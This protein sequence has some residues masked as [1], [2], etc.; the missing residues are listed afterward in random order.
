MNALDFIENIINNNNLYNANLKYCLINKDKI[1][2]KYNNELAKPNHKEDF[3]DIDTL[4]S[5]TNINDYAGIGVSIQASHIYA[6]DVDKCF[7]EPFNI[8]TADERAIDIIDIFKNWCYIEF[9]F[10]GTGLRLF[11]KLEKDI[12]LNLYKTKYYTKNAKTKCEFYQPLDSARYV[13]ITGKYIL[14]NNIEAENSWSVEDLIL[15][16]NKYMKKE[17]KLNTEKIE[18]SDDIDIDKA[19]KKLKYYILTDAQFQDLWFSK[20]PGSGADESERD[21]HIIKFIYI[22]ITSNKQV[23][24][25]LFESSPFFKSKDNKHMFKWQQSDYRYYNYI[26]EQIKLGK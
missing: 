16:L 24:K 3:I 5:N 10:S 2:Y 13:T 19:R 21:Y 17:E 25:E 8:D 11:F 18:A 26:Y 23:I 20:A 7:R 22:N 1:P 6:I 4:I 15:F 9:S 12:D 14:N